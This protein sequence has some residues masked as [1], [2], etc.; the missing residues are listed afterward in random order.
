MG[1][2]EREDPEMVKTCFIL[3]SNGS[4][5]STILSDD[6]AFCDWPVFFAPAA[7]SFAGLA[8]AAAA[9][10][11]MDVFRKLRLVVFMILL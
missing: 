10:T 6:N 11:A 5:V 2:V 8:K 7:N 1:V 3:A 9:A 4:K